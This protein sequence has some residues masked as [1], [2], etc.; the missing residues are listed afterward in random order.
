MPAVMAS[1]VL[2]GI[3]GFITCAFSTWVL[4]QKRTELAT[5]TLKEAYLPELEQSLLEPETK[6]AVMQA[7]TELA[8]DMERGKLEDWQSA[9]V[10]QRLQRLPVLQ[11]GDLQAIESFVIKTGTAQQG[12]EA[13]KQFDRLRY[14]VAAGRGTSFDFYDV[15]SPTQVDDPELPSGRRLMQPLELEACMDTVKRSELLADR[16]Q[17]AVDF[18][19][20]T[21]DKSLRIETIMRDEIRDAIREGGF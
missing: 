5:R 13:T 17:V 4:Y 1:V 10:M 19:A 14:S 21:S 3:I 11:W 16:E 9:G 18:D 20:S 6:A 8:A 12:A 2:M 15:L 7:V